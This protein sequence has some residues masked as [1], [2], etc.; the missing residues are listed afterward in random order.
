MSKNNPNSNEQETYPKKTPPGPDNNKEVKPTDQG[1]NEQETPPK[2][3]P[4]GKDEG[5]EV[6]S[7]DQGGNERE[8]PPQNTPPGTNN[9]EEIKPTDQGGSEQETPRGRTPPGNGS[10]S[11]NKPPNQ[12]GNEQITPPRGTPASEDEA[13]KEDPPYTPQAGDHRNIKSEEIK[14]LNMAKK[15]TYNYYINKGDEK[16][17]KESKKSEKDDTNE[18]LIDPTKSLP[19]NPSKLSVF[20]STKEIEDKIE[21][22][23]EE[24]LMMVSCQCEDIS[25]STAYK[26]L[27]KNEFASYERRMLSF[28]S[29][30]SSRSD[31]TLDIFLNHR[32]GSGGKMIV[33]I[34]IER[35]CPFFDSLFIRKIPAQFIKEEFQQKKIL[36]I[37]LL[38]PYLMKQAMEE[39]EFSFGYWEI[40]FL[41]HLLRN[42]FPQGS[43]NLIEEILRQR[44]KGLWD[45]DNS[46]REFF[47]LIHNYILDGRETFEEQ[48]RKL[49]KIGSDKEKL[50]KF[51]ANDSSMGD[52]KE[53]FARELFVDKE[54][55]KT[56][57]YVGTFFPGLTPLDFD[58]VVHELLEDKA[59][60]VEK[61]K[62]VIGK[63]GEVEKI[64]EKEEIKLLEVW[65]K[66][67]DSILARCHLKA[68][69]ASDGSQYM[70]FAYPYLKNDLK[71]YI[72]ESHP[73]YLRRQFT[74]IQSSDQ[75]F[76]SLDVSDSITENII[77]LAANM[78]I[79][80][81]VYYGAE[82]LKKFIYQVK[83]Q[84]NI[85]Y[86]PTDNRFFAIWQFLENSENEVIQK[87][88]Y[89][90][91]SRL[92]REMLNHRQLKEVV[93]N[94]L[95]DLFAN[96][97][98]DAVLHIA[99][100]VGKPLLFVPR[101][102]F[103]LFYWLKRLLDQG[104][105]EIK[106]ETY[107]SLIQIAMERS[108][109]IY[110]IM[111][112]IRT[113]LP[114]KKKKPDSISHS[115]KYALLF[116][117]NYCSETLDQA[118][119][120][121][122]EKLYGQGLSTYPLFIPLK[123]DNSSREERLKN[124]VNWLLHPLVQDLVKDL[125]EDVLREKDDGEL[126]DFEINAYIA[127]L[128]EEWALVL[129]G[130]EY[131]KE[132][133]REKEII[134]LL[135]RQVALNTDKAR[136]REIINGLVKSRIHYR[137]V[138]D[139]Y[140]WEKTEK[141]LLITRYQLTRMLSGQLKQLMAEH[142]IGGK[143]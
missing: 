101:F 94:F 45:R 124:I 130:Q 77:R 73:I 111:D 81:P 88:F 63:N 91:V 87:H 78:A 21:E 135:L 57:L 128:L 129:L 110:D 37:G 126:F 61:E 113:W 141:E 69:P 42:Y 119:K 18:V 109:H 95:N 58:R 90:Q 84:Y 68:V 31:L 98:H 83:A 122:K 12:S 51:K 7:T 25:S 127:D 48:V 72:E 50:A 35:Q 29:Y 67:A 96:K 143:K 60:E 56:V 59:I 114:D 34:D 76:F 20:H 1:G 106:Y 38:N 108:L 52:I 54:P 16:K 137:D 89:T 102:D 15:I 107:E 62:S 33:F 17:S 3:T 70:D 133:S 99:L 24:R 32:I 85:Q 134:D 13:E 23:K 142:S 27:E 6:N 116:I 139:E 40:D 36:L 55:D 118:Q 105:D 43:D 65:E 140:E 44:E 132:H 22:W 2:K 47:K 8:T 138:I 74:Q 11:G 121:Y 125:V 80:N 64:T 120:K 117:V 71:K 66:E 104:P 123:K 41:P 30:N 26:L 97:G 39:R 103:D 10:N 92:I 9:G 79:L 86:E 28:E 136:Q 115:S 75:L 14:N 46:D 93:K 131:K 100:N 49:S 53:V 19:G 4:Q 5:K 112:V 82:W